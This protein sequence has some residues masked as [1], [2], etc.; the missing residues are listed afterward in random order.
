MGSAT[1]RTVTSSLLTASC[2]RFGTRMGECYYH[3]PDWALATEV[4]IE[5]VKT[6]Q[7]TDVETAV[8]LA[9]AREADEA[10]AWAVYWLFAH[11]I[12]IDGRS[13]GNGQHRVCAM[14]VAGIS[15]CPIED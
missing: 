6:R 9:E 7:D 10:T 1:V 5:A 12:F 2:A 15:R 13:L 8:A 3:E 14:K 4:A 11:P